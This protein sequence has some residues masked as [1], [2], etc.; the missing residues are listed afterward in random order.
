MH[1]VYLDQSISKC[2]SLLHISPKYDSGL[3]TFILSKADWC[4]HPHP[5]GWVD[6]SHFPGSRLQ[7]KY[8]T[9]EWHVQRICFFFSLSRFCQANCAWA[10]KSRCGIW[11]I[12]PVQ[13]CVRET[14][15]YN[16]PHLA[17]ACVA[18]E[19]ICHEIEQDISLPVADLELNSWKLKG[20]FL[21][22][23]HFHS[24]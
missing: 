4:S 9:R 23:C 14:E 24:H 22:A 19:F 18:G 11:A 17:V 10:G 15:V 8:C 6:P 7:S 5:G 2:A 21:L 13:E 1:G 12:W 16:W 3:K 20:I